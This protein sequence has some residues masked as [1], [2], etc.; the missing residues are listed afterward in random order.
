[1]PSVFKPRE[2]DDFPFVGVYRTLVKVICVGGLVL[3][4][5]LMLALGKG[6]Y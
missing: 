2:G 5:G 6:L 3:V 4:S 1:M